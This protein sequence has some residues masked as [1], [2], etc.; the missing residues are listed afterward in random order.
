[1]LSDPTVAVRRGSGRGPT[2]DA[3]AE[4][5]VVPEYILYFNQQW[6][7]EHSDEWFR[8]RAA[9]AMAVVEAMKAAG[10]HL[11]SGGLEEEE[12]P[13]YSADPTGGSVVISDGPYAETKEYLGGFAIVDVPDDKAAT[14]WA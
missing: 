3:R 8:G 5:D 2:R 9:P 1:M 12:G 10:V 13:V 14:M 7:G 4:G 11:F 6:V